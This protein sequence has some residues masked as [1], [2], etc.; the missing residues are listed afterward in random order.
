MP[1]ILGGNISI[2]GTR[3]NY[4]ISARNQYLIC[5]VPKNVILPSQEIRVYE[6]VDCGWSILVYRRAIF[7]LTSLIRKNCFIFSTKDYDRID[8]RCVQ[9]SNTILP[10]VS[11]PHLLIFISFSHLFTIKVYS[12]HCH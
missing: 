1:H 3:I 4:T 10:F 7:Y 5:S 6:F 2:S 12:L 8:K 11:V 9:S